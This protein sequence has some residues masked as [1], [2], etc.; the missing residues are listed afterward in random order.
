MRILHWTEHWRPLIGG[1]EV[2]VSHLSQEQARRGHAVTV[3]TERPLDSLEAHEQEGTVEIH[4]LPMARALAS[5]DTTQISMCLRALKSMLN[6]FSP[7]VIH[8]HTKNAS[9]WFHR[10]AGVARSYPAVATVHAP[11]SHFTAP[12]PLLEQFWRD[13]SWITSV[14]AATNKELGEAFPV[15]A[16]KSSVVLN[17][18]PPV[19]LEQLPA[20]SEVPVVLGLGRLVEEKGFDLAIRA[21]VSWRET[22]PNAV[23]WIAGVGPASEALKQLA[24]SLHPAEH[25][26]FWGAVEPVKVPALIAQ[27]RFVVMPSRW[28]EP[29]GLVAVQAGQS[30]R[31]VVAARIGGLPEIVADGRTGLLFSPGDEA[32][33]AAQGR[34][35][36]LG[37]EFAAELGQAAKAH[38]ETHFSLSACADN[39]GVI[40]EQIRR[41]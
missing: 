29:F 37:P 10:L 12:Q 33:L 41:T 9:I 34:R 1:V 8:L 32:D 26:R 17:G 19:N 16:E 39:F 4:R 18:M 35:L 28:P 30:A 31:A 22:A 13:V 5:K 2:L 15:T 25:V 20:Q 38:V 24:L 21:F 7:D 23:L 11:L 14:S 27:S 3:L 40:Y 6:A 36:L